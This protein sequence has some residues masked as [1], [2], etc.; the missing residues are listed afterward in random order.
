MFMKRLHL[1]ENII[2]L[3]LWAMIFLR[4]VIFMDMRSQSGDDALFLWEEI[5]RV[6]KV[7][8]VYL[9]I[10][11]I[12]NFLLTPFLLQYKKKALYF[13]VTFCLVLAFMG[14]QY[15]DN[16]DRRGTREA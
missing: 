8:A 16:S 5:W 3:V 9:A 13:V 10:F 7:Y 1:H 12:H 2:Y 11:L 4:P 14:C 6:W 15:G